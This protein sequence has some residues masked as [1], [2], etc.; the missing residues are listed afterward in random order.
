MTTVLKVV[1]LVS[2]GIFAGGLVMVAGAIVPTF[3]ALPP[4]AYVQMHQ[5]LS[6][7]V[8]RFMPATVLLAIL[9][10]FALTWLQTGVVRAL[11]IAGVLLSIAVAI[12]SQFGNVPINRK[13]RSWNPEAPPPETK[14]M[15]ERWRRLHLM[16]TCAGVLAMCVFVIAAVL[17][18]AG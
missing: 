2:S 15:V 18:D 7:Y 3:R 9:V 14:D 8:D 12:I 4:K 10:G 11:L 17:P 16:R 1:L 5:T 13:V 6:R